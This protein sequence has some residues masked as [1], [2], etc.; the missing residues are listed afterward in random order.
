MAKIEMGKDFDAYLSALEKWEKKDSV[1]VMMVQ[2]WCWMHCIR[3]YP[4]GRE[5]IQ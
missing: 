3:R 2:V 1:P 4:H 5:V